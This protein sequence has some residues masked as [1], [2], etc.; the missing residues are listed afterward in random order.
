MSRIEKNRRQIHDIMQQLIY[1]EHEAGEYEHGLQICIF[2][3]EKIC[4]YTGDYLVSPG[5][6]TPKGYAPGKIWRTGINPV[7]T[8]TFEPKE[9]NGKDD[10]YI[11]KI[12]KCADKK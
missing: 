7:Q 2:C 9:N 6:F 4:D 1:I 12:I 11:R 5:G 3:G 10:P 8:T